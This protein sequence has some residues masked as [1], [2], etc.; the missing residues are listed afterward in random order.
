MQ[1]LT[2]QELRQLEQDAIAEYAHYAGIENQLI[3]G[4]KIKIH[5]L[6]D[7]SN[8]EEFQINYWSYII[9]IIGIVMKY[10]VVGGTIKFS[11]WLIIK[12]RAAVK[13]LILVLGRFLTNLYQSFRYDISAKLN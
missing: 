6:K 1:L 9:E 12:N 2:E 10:F 3:D 4:N 11:I 8:E 7:P 5:T 13:D